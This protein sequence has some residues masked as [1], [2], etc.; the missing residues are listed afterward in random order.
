MSQ[1]LSQKV[2]QHQVVVAGKGSLHRLR[3]NKKNPPQALKIDQ[4]STKRGYVT[5]ILLDK[6]QINAVEIS[7]GLL[8]DIR[9]GR[10]T[11]PWD[12]L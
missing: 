10:Q 3:K 12:E 2:I 4:L 5:D 11:I 1:H 7:Q 8:H 9:A 6:E